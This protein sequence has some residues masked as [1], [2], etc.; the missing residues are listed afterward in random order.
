MRHIIFSLLLIVSYSFAKA[1]ISYG[2][3]PKAGKYCRL[4]GISM[5]YEIYGKGEPLLL[6]HGNS[7]SINAFRENIPELSKHFMV[8]ATDSRAQGKSV[9]DN[10]SLSFEMMADDEAALLDSLHIKQAHVLGWSDGGIVAIVMAIRH[11]GKVKKIISTGA[12]AWPDST[13]II[14]SLWKEGKNIFDSTNASHFTGWKK[15]EWKLF[16]LDY[17]QPNLTLQQLQQ[18]RCPALIIGGDND[19]IRTEHTVVISQ[20]I[21][22]AFLWIVPHSGHGTLTEHKKEFNAISIDFLKNTWKKN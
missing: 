12:N 10:D 18:I 2:N 19:L 22:G 7:G 13:A 14:P 3:N 16:M 9:D 11:P 5:Y 21:P 4:R 6:V 15:N 1:Q 20:N 8:I 17:N